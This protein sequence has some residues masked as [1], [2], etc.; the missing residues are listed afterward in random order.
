MIV[1]SDQ[2]QERTMTDQFDTYIT[3]AWH[4]GVADLRAQLPRAAKA[5]FSSSRLANT[6]RIF[7]QIL[8]G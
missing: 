4:F 8:N 2:Q 6:D 3:E 5:E 1:P 7:P